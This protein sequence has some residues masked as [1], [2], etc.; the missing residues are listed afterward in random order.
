MNKLL[1]FKLRLIVD[2]LSE[3]AVSFRAI[4]VNNHI[5]AYFVCYVYFQVKLIP[6][7][8]KSDKKLTN[9][10]SINIRP[11]SLTLGATQYLRLVI[12]RSMSYA[13][14]LGLD[15]CNKPDSHWNWEYCACVFIQPSHQKISKFP[16][17]QNAARL[18]RIQP[19]SSYTPTNHPI[20]IYKLNNDLL[21]NIIFISW[22]HKLCC[23][24]ML[25]ILIET[26]SSIM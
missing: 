17:R 25:S 21:S 14:N 18:T 13:W 20:K 22:S 9:H 3:W 11:W 26:T 6:D 23:S 5:I 10:D 2:N 24:T 4:V 16:I 7:Q 12:V 15:V 8:C 19:V 1:Q